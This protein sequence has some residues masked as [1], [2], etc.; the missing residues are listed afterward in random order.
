[1]AELVVGLALLGVRQ[2]LVGF[3]RL[4]ELLLGLWVIRIAVRMELHGQAAV[5][6]LD[7]V[8]PGVAV[9]AEDFVKVAFGGSH[10][11]ITS[12]L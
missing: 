1:M 8:I 7:L 11:V 6:L 3:F 9:D 12:C 5:G 10:A 2:D 4:L